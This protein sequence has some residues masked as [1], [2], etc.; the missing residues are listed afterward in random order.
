MWMS[1]EYLRNLVQLDRKF[2]FFELLGAVFYQ[3]F[4]KFR[5][6]RPRA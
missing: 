3:W 2:T 6:F 5:L 4:L 1:A